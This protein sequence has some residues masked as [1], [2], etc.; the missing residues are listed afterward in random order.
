MP[1][2]PFKFKQFEIYQDNSAMK[3][4]TDAILLSVWAR[5]TKA[6]HILDVGT[7][8]G[9]ISLICAQRND[10]ATI[11]GIEIDSGGF[12]DASLNFA[13]SPWSNR[14]IAHHSDFLDFTTEKTYDVIISNPP[15]FTNSL[16]A[17]DPSRSAARHDDS[18]PAQ[19]FLEKSASLLNSEGLLAVIFP[20]NQ[21]EKWESE[22]SLHG[23]YPVRICN[24]FTLPNRESQRVL[25]EYKKQAC[26]I[27]EMESILIEKIPGQLSEHFKSL[28][29]DFFNKGD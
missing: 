13:N 6:Y 16:R 22:A 3:V 21:F 25:V 17:S 23:L 2:K 19:A 29:K 18:L 26:D 24:V 1:N 9:I 14:L 5:V 28:T 20:K 15:Y 27:P 11:E 10:R 4:G 12:A 7:G 8:T